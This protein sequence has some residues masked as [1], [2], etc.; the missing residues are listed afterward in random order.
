MYIKLLVLFGF[1]IISSI[2]KLHQLHLVLH[3]LFF[4]GRELKLVEAVSGV[5]PVI[6]GLNISGV[7]TYKILRGGVITPGF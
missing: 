3:P 4:F 6:Q 7:I 2:Y 5:I 1:S